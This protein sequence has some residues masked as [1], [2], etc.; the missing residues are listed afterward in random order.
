MIQVTSYSNPDLDGFSCAYAYAEFLNMTETEAKPVIFGK[1]RREVQFVVSKFNID[2][3]SD[4]FDIKLDVA[5]VDASD[6][7]GVLE[8]LDLEKV[9]EVIDHREVHE[10]EGFKKAKLQIELV[11]SAATLI[12]E[13]FVEAKLEP[14]REAAVLLYSAIISNTINF[15]N[16]VTT[17]RD[18]D[19]AN[20]FPR[21]R[22][23]LYSRDV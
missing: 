14:S 6:V 7:R 4:D 13:K 16:N 22:T 1:P 21:P 23:K 8:K 19:A 20:W 11:G 3:P 17:E 12:T 15:K 10:S 18:I 2:V 9:I 5:L